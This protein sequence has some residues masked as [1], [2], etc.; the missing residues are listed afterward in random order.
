MHTRV[1]KYRNRVTQ[2]DTKQNV[3]LLANQRQ[4]IW[5]EQECVVGMAPDSNRNVLCV[6]DTIIQ[7]D[8]SVQVLQLPPTLLTVQV[9][10]GCKVTERGR[11]E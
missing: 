2:P 7:G 6:V 11:H 5:R 3:A 9:G 1:Q 4:V 8:K 10:T